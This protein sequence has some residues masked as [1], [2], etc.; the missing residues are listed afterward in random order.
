MALAR[1]LDSTGMRDVHHHLGLASNDIGTERER[2]AFAAQGGAGPDEEA[3][4]PRQ[5]G[6]QVSKAAPEATLGF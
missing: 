2:K 3:E 5:H 6:I 1:E 4:K